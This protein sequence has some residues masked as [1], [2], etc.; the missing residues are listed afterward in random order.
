MGKRFRRK[1]LKAKL[2]GLKGVQAFAD[3]LTTLGYD[4]YLVDLD[5][6]GTG[7]MT[8]AVNN[9]DDADRVVTY[10][11]GGGTGLAK[12]PG[13]LDDAYN[14]LQT[15]ERLDAGLQPAP[16]TA[17]TVR[18]YPV[19]ELASLGVLSQRHAQAASFGLARYQH[20]LN[21]VRD[22]A[23][24]GT[25]RKPARHS[26]VSHSYGCLLTAMTAA[27]YGLHATA[28]SLNGM[29]GTSLDHASQLDLAEVY[30][31]MKDN[32]AFRVAA[33]LRFLHNV[34][35]ATRG[36]G[37]LKIRSDPGPPGRLLKR[38]SWKSHFDYWRTDLATLYNNAQ[39]IRGEAPDAVLA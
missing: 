32:D 35:P 8:L 38:Y 17:L 2:D 20:S 36:Y 34:G 29:I 30:A 3:E 11:P 33:G 13:C 39:I 18:L 1:R 26:V 24:D 7:T 9:P 21:V 6:T 27:A 19:P 16:K 5:T 22:P 15:V 31:A 14:L 4:V 10:V 23:A 12:A 28:A 25:E 37:A